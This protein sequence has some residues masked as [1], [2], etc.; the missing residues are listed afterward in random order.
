[1]TGHGFR[2]QEPVAAATSVIAQLLARAVQSQVTVRERESERERER[3]RK[4]EREDRERERERERERVLIGR[5]SLVYV[6]VRICTYRHNTHTFLCT[7]SPCMSRA[8]LRSKPCTNSCARTHARQRTIRWDDIHN[9]TH[10]HMHTNARVC[11]HTHRPRINQ[12]DTQRDTLQHIAPHCNTPQFTAPHYPTLP[13]TALH[14]NTLQHTTPHCNTLQQTAAQLWPLSLSSLTVCCAGVESERIHTQVDA[15]VAFVS[16]VSNSVV[17][18]V[19]TRHRTA[20]HQKV[21]SHN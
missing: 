4:R 16:V 20:R 9:A 11:V 8:N 1:M 6:Y 18:G 14:C 15:S 5:V 2:R 21:R 7:H 19:R 13:H 3:E 10:K 12:D 17:C